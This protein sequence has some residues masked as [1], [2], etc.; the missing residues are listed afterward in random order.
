MYWREYRT[1]FHSAQSFGVSEPTVC[2]TIKG[3][4]DCLTQSS[5]FAVPGKK[6]LTGSNMVFEVVLLDA[7]ESPLERPQK[8][9]ATTTTVARRSVIRSLKSQV[10]A[11]LR[12]GT[13]IFKSSRVALSTQTLCLADSG[14]QGITK[15]HA[16]SQTPKK[17]SKHHPV[18]KEEKASN[19]F[20]SRHRVMIEHLCGRLQVF[21]ILSERYR[22]RRR[23]FGLRFN[24][25]AAIYNRELATDF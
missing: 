14:Y 17:R 19:R 25:I 18:T 13:I 15:V 12:S 4:E 23:R 9:S 24:L 5:K 8:G 22:T 3:V 6:A 1:Q 2:R 16:L 10:L 21:K 20:L 7:S 11:D